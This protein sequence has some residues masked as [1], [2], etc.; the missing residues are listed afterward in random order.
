M[1]A[2]QLRKILAGCPDNMPVIM[3]TSRTPAY[4]TR[5]EWVAQ[6]MS[7][8]LTQSGLIIRNTNNDSL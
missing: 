6:V 3:A 1:T 4:R 5:D 7:A 2:K 8:S